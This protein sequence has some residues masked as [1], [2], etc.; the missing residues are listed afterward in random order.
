MSWNNV[1][2]QGKIS[3]FVQFVVFFQKNNTKLSM[4]KLRTNMTIEEWENTTNYTC[5]NS[6]KYRKYPTVEKNNFYF[7]Y[8]P[9]TPLQHF[10]YFIAVYI[11]IMF[12]YDDDFISS[13]ESISW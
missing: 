1:Q 7:Y 6:E 13:I 10:L 4:Q 12:S 5:K 11:L 9:A 3:V 2:I 8:L